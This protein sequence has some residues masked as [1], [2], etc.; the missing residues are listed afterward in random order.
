MSIERITVR[1]A[2][3]EFD[4]LTAGPAR[5][6]LVLLLHGFP[7]SSACWRGALAT[8]GAAGFHAVAPD[9]RGYSAG[10]RPAG[11]AAYRV[12]ELTR[13]AVDIAAAL[14]AER[15]H[16]VGHDW[17]GTVAWALAGDEPDRILSLTAISTPH[18]A[19][20]ARALRETRQRAR[21]SYIPVLRLPLVAEAIFQTAGG[22]VAEQALVATGLPRLL[23]RRD[24]AAIR[25]VGATGPLNWYRALGLEPRPHVHEVRVPTLYVWGT[26]DVA[27]GRQAAEGTEGHVTGPYHFVELQGASHWIPDLHWDDI[28][29]LV[30][31]HL[32]EGSAPV[33][34]ASAK[35]AARPKRAA[36]R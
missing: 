14:G 24:L 25:R 21:M 26:E 32:G 8:L 27:F 23:A 10:A 11:V 34:R 22:L 36:A 9:Q 16:V 6:P 12:G 31:E 2:G 29:D 20:L 4:A 3:F 13:D 1:A 28:E 19:A 17:G 35:R 18:T 33:K 15:F 5:G 7:Q 30:L